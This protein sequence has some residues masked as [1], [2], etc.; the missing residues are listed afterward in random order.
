MQALEIT[1]KKHVIPQTHHYDIVGEF[2]KNASKTLS[3]L[4]SR[5]ILPSNQSAPEY[6]P[7]EWNDTG[8]LRV[9]E[10]NALNHLRKNHTNAYFSYK[11]KYPSSQ[12]LKAMSVDFAI[13]DYDDLVK[14][15]HLDIDS[16]KNLHE[17]QKIICNLLQYS[18]NCYQYAVNDKTIHNQGCSTNPN[19]RLKYKKYS[20]YKTAVI[21][22]IIKDGGIYAGRNLPEIKNNHYRIALAFNN[23]SYEPDYHFIRENKIGDKA[24]WSHK[25]GRGEVIHKDQI[26]DIITCPTDM[27]MNNYKI[28]H[29]FQIPTGGLKTTPLRPS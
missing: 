10:A 14:E 8:I 24:I 28:E 29:Y 12:I 13:T 16:I 5:L 2:T 17:T 15:L 26:D 18:T 3:D 4:E 23:L 25:F 19:G 1:E 20:G 9:Y 11:H 6:S 22:G 7:N 27:Y 21:R